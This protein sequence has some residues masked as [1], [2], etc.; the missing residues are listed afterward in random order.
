LASPM[1]ARRFV[2]SPWF[3]LTYFGRNRRRV[4]P[5]LGI[6]I[7]AV[8]GISLAGA[9]AHDLLLQLGVGPRLYAQPAALSG[10]ERQRVAIARALANDPE[11]LFADE[12]TAAL[13]HD[14]AQV[15][16]DLLRGYARE[17]A[18]VVTHDHSLLR[19]GDRVYGMSGGRLAPLVVEAAAVTAAPGRHP[20]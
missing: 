17:R 7:F 11:V 9:L 6:L 4:I 5:V 16:M 20:Q 8:F 13:D 12:P 3:L 19:P 14:N 1:L 2:H 18:V 10:G 15:V